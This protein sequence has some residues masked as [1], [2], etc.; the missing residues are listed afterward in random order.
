[1]VVYSPLAR[2]VLT[3]KYRENEPAEAGSRAARADKRLMQT[4]YRP[5]SLTLAQRFKAHAERRGFTASRF[6]TAWVLNNR[7]VAGVIAGPRTLEQWQDYVAAASIVL[8]AD[9]EG[10][11]DSLVAPGHASTHGYTDPLYPV[12]GRRAR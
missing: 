8:T 7:L 2:G 3:G 9:D 6:A 4:E 10:F 11:V 5:E 1:V 12:T